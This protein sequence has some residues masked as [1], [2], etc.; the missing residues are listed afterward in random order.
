MLLAGHVLFTVLLVIGTVRAVAGGPLTATGPV[1]PLVLAVITAAWYGAGA[2][3][4]AGDAA[5]RRSHAWLAGLLLLW[6]ALVGVSGEFIWLA[7]LLAMLVWHLVPAR[8]AAPVDIGVAVVAVV[9]FAWHQGEVQAG[10]VIGPAVGIA[11]AVVMTE[12]YHRLRAQSEERRRLL[13]QLVRTQAALADRERAAG[14]LAEREHLAREIHD[15]VG[16]SLSSVILLLRAALADTALTGA[17]DDHPDGRTPAPPSSAAPDPDGAQ[18]AHHAHRI[19]LQ[20]ALDS[21]L[22]ALGE[23]RR[24]VRGL[25]PESIEKHGLRTALEALAVENRAMGVRTTFTE[26]GAPH[27]LPRRSEVALLRAAQEAVT[28]TRKH[29]DADSVAITLTHQE[30][31]TSV[32]IV[33]NGRGF[34]AHAPL[35]PQLD[36]SGYGLAAMRA[37]IGECD[38]D[39]VVESGDGHGTAVRATV[40]T[41]AS[42]R[43]GE[44]A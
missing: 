4:V 39:V 35:P 11:S 3:R 21:T 44:D 1:A 2:A 41:I 25:D 22:A 36:G 17:A 7:F 33:D 27:P 30:D 32:D 24:L 6:L 18:R 16:Q 13:E 5:D 31:E 38:G 8:V 20:T 42:A 34:D 26:H 37:R 28:N 23:T 40:P 15:T 10:A 29:A 43:T 9:G 19:Q 14:R 12:I